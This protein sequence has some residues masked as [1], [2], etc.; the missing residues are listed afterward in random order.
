M[1]LFQGDSILI[2][3][4]VSGLPT[5][6]KSRRA[7]PANEEP[8]CNSSTR[9]TLSFGPCP[10]TARAVS[11]LEQKGQPGALISDVKGRWDSEAQ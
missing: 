5:R 7:V 3:R 10:G 2:L 6:K 9:V 1:L 8:V 4:H 11:P